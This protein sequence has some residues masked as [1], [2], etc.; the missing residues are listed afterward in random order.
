MTR[1]M[2]RIFSSSFWV[3]RTLG[4]SGENRVHPYIFRSPSSSTRAEQAST[5]NFD[6]QPRSVIEFLME[7]A[8]AAARILDNRSKLVLSIDPR[9]ASTSLNT[10]RF[11]S[12]T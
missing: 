1:T 10:V 9:L 6:D 2:S 4:S 5:E 7:Y 8:L 11:L 12:P 3:Y